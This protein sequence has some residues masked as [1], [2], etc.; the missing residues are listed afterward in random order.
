MTTTTAT[1]RQNETEDL[2]AFIAHF[3]NGPS[4]ARETLLL[5]DGL[6]RFGR[7]VRFNETFFEDRL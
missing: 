1:Q 5:V 2:E 3:V 4:A 6:S 7:A